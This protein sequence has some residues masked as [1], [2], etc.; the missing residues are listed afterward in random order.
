MNEIFC[1]CRNCYFYNRK[2][3]DDIREPI[4][5]EI[6]KRKVYM[7]SVESPTVKDGLL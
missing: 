3:T 5:D 6:W 1:P 4:R 7:T 2:N